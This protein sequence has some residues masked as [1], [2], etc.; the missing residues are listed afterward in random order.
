MNNYLYALSFTLFLISF[1]SFGKNSSFQ[2]RFCK[3][4]GY[5]LMLVKIGDKFK[6]KIDYMLDEFRDELESGEG[7][8]FKKGFDKGVRSSINKRRR[9]ITASKFC[10]QSKDIASDITDTFKYRMREINSN[11]FDPLEG[12]R[13]VG[14]N[15]SVKCEDISAKDDFWKQLQISYIEKACS[16]FSRD[17]DNKKNVYPRY[18]YRKQLQLLYVKYKKKEDRKTALK[19]CET[20][21]DEYKQVSAQYSK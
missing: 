14:S 3:Q 13:P 15:P 8:P 5:D 6:S 11:E 18:K 16:S 10:S 21:F 9:G 20:L 4:G 19:I 12:A 1:D 2:A 7:D 17:C